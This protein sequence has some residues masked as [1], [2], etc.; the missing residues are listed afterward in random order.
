MLKIRRFLKYQKCSYCGNE[1]LV[2]C[3]DRVNKTEYICL[4]CKSTK[5][6]YSKNSVIKG[7]EKDISYSFEFE[8]SSRCNELY[9]LLKYKFLS[10]YDCSIGG[11]EWKSPIFYSLKSFHFVCRKIDKFARYVGNECGTHLHVSTKYK[12]VLNAYEKEIFQPI[13]D[14]MILNCEKTKKFWGRYFGSYCR[15]DISN[16]RYN[17]FNTRSSV[18]TLE[19]RLLKFINAEQYIKAA[20]FCIAIT[21]Y[22][23]KVIEKTDDFGVSEATI[24]GKE[25]VKKYKE[26]IKDV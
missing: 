14:E 17:S 5:E 3:L 7:K 12:H 21:R 1:Y 13:L 11:Y 10:C 16:S 22:L 25:I 2:R 15:N 8:T 19:F 26:A 9:E 23:N 24:L 4:D 6:Y 18:E 20:D